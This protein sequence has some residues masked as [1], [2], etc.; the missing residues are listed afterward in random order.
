MRK[1]DRLVRLL[2]SDIENKALLEAACGTADFSVSASKFASSVCCIDLDASRLNNQLISDKICFQIMDAAD[3]KFPDNS[4]DTVVLYNAFSRI[5]MQ[6]AVSLA[7][8]SHYIL[9]FL[10][11]RLNL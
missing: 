5:Q 10:N 1:T 9:P 3:M 4:F 7:E 6:L 11:I 2:I 8:P